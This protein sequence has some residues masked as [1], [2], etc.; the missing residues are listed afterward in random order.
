[1]GL[2]NYKA[3]IKMFFSIFIITCLIQCVISLET[4][5]KT[6]KFTLKQGKNSKACTCKYTLKWDYPDTVFTTGSSKVVCTVKGWPKKDA[7]NYPRTTTFFIG[8]FSSAVTTAG[9]KTS[10]WDL[11]CPQEDKIIWGDLGDPAIV[12]DFTISNINS[13]SYIECAK[14]C[15]EFVNEAGNAPCFSWV[16]N[17]NTYTMLDLTPGTCRLYGYKDVY[18][19]S[20]TGVQSGYHKCYP[21]MQQLG[22]V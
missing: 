21:A 3:S 22:L 4:F 6:D 13:D 18:K 16:L 19:L 2:I 14:R 10:P 12:N 9:N 5:S 17:S 20:A 7:I 15:T 11:W 1:M 8:N